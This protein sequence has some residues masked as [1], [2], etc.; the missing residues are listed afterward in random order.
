MINFYR[1]VSPNTNKVHVGSTVK[2]IEKRL[3][4][5]ETDYKVF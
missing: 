3:K 5:H 4:L 1:I 2:P